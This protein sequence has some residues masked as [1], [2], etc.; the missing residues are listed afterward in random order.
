L[1][2]SKDSGQSGLCDCENIVYLCGMNP[3]IYATNVEL[4]VGICG[5]RSVRESPDL[6][7]AIDKVIEKITQAYS[8][9]SLK[10][11]SPLAEGADCIVTKRMLS[12]SN[13][14]L[15][16]LLPF[17][18]EDYLEDFSTQESIRE[19]RDLYQQARQVIELPGSMV[20]E[21]AYVALGRTLLDHSTILVAIWNGKPANG[22]GGTAEIVL[23]ARQRR[24]PLAWILHKQPD[25]FGSEM[26][27]SK[28]ERI[29]IIFER[30]PSQNSI[31]DS[32]K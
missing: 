24:L 2:H 10:L 31:P 11:V 3:E 1:R 7:S 8:F 25:S 16:A 4:A 6:L 17:T 32:E 12:T 29:W 20:R 30:F 26:I 21:E 18:T 13:A 22:K 28:E 9:Q 19:F 27:P 15:V 5:H 14:S 23:E